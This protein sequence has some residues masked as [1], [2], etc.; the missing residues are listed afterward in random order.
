MGTEET[1]DY[2]GC[3]EAGRDSDLIWVETASVVE[4]VV[5]GYD[6]VVVVDAG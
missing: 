4:A 5:V 2:M 6:A 1:V 3:V